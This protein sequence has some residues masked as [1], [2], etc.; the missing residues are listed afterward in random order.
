MRFKFLNE[1]NLIVF[2][3]IDW[4]KDSLIHLNLFYPW[5]KRA[6]SILFSVQKTVR[7]RSII[8]EL[9]NYHIQWTLYYPMKCRDSSWQCDNSDNMVDVVCPNFIHTL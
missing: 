3:L 4:V 9:P 2:K 5:M 8:S 6:A 1:Q 7:Q